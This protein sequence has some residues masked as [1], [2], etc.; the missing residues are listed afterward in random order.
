MSSLVIKMATDLVVAQTHAQQ[1]TPDEARE[2]LFS[3]HATLLALQSQEAVGTSASPGQPSAA[4]ARP[5]WRSSILRHAITC[6]E[7][8]ATFKQLS[9][10]HLRT[11]DLDPRSY[12]DKYGIPRTQ[13]LS[14]RAITAHRRQ[15]AHRI[16]P[17]E[18]AHTDRGAAS[19]TAETSSQT[20]AAQSRKRAS[21]S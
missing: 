21:S 8:G 2:L 5:D 14:A 15:L 4:V 6:M 19:D 11:H 9:A 17:W 10:R 16:R 1:L 20:P 7:C 3:T 12:R 13:A 18:L